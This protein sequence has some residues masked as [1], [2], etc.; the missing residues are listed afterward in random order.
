MPGALLLL[1]SLTLAQEPPRTDWKA[2]GLYRQRN[3]AG[4]TSWRLR[5]EDGRVYFLEF[6]P[7]T[8]MQQRARLWDGSKVTLEHDPAVIWLDHQ[9]ILPVRNIK[10]P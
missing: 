4:D 1:A 6:D 3:A 10:P 5:G 8:R 2:G 9:P 7:T